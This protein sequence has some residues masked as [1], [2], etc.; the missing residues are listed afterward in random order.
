MTTTALHPWGFETPDSLLRFRDFLAA[1]T[2]G[3][4][5][6][7]ADL[8][9]SSAGVVD[10]LADPTR[11]P[12]PGK[13]FRAHGRY[14]CDPPEFLTFLHG[15]SDGLHHGLWFDDGRTCA[16]V[17][18]YYTHDGGGIEY[19]P[20][21]TPL[22]TVRDTLERV[23]RDLHDDDT[24]DPAV[25]ARIE[26]AAQ[27]RTD[28]RAFET[29]D[30]PETGLDYSRA[31]DRSFF[32]SPAEPARLTTLDGAGA[33]VTG[34]TILDRPPHNG[35]DEEKFAQYL[36][37]RFD[38]P[39]TVAAWV[40]EARARC[41]AGDPAEALV[42]G[43]DLHWASWGD[44]VREAQAHEL[45]VLAYT[46]LDRPLLAELVTAVREHRGQPSV[47]VLGGR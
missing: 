35:A 32:R 25:T 26:A 46:A 5:R 27:L 16:G 43:R 22:T 37:A 11:T 28:I 38:E 41:A 4:A 47:D 31:H 20:T 9:V 24:T 21:G 14:Y 1:L 29:D 23:W 3:S 45:L 17:A 15:G 44:P 2:P 10:V 42:L 7:L 34:D 12:L 8:G 40:T 33:L 13:E 18:S 39:E 36:Y 6:A 30:R 19:D